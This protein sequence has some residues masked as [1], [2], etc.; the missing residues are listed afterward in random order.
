MCRKAV[1][2]SINQNQKAQNVT[3]NSLMLTDFFLFLITKV[4]SQ[5][6]AKDCVPFLR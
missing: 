3:K 6:F 2:Q 4:V 5:Q 1:N